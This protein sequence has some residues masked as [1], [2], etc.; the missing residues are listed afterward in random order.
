M[1]VTVGKHFVGVMETEIGEG[2][3][4]KNLFGEWKIE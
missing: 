2:N 4:F 1:K 3:V